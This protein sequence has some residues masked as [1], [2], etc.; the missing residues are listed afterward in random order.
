MGSDFA[1]RPPRAAGGASRP[2]PWHGSL[3]GTERPD[4]LDF[5]DAD[6][7]RLRVAAWAGQGRG[8]ALLLPGRTEYLEKYAPVVAQ[9]TAR[10]FSVASLDWRGQ[11]ASE[12]DA[13]VAR[14]GHVGDFAEYQTDLDVLMRWVEGRYGAGGVQL[15]VAHSMGGCIALRAVAD[16]ALATPERRPEALV[17]SAPMWGLAM[18][19]VGA[20]LVKGLARAAVRFGFGRRRARGTS[21]E[22]TYVLDAPLEENVLVQDPDVWARFRRE[23]EAGPELTL[24]SPTLA[25]VD[26]ALRE[27]NALRRADVAGLPPRL[28]LLGDEEGVVSSSAIR[29]HASRGFGADLAV[30]ADARHEPL[31]EPPNGRIGRDVWSAVDGF[32]RARAA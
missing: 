16:G 31:M 20:V 15:A 4:A 13:D 2:A 30:I 6:G 10:G 29:E 14:L 22:T 32:L 1:T 26:A 5:L 12:R 27:M 7:I 21:S 9:L 3:S 19:G 28:L 17:F 24:G 18:P 25:W 11:G 23:A 8:L